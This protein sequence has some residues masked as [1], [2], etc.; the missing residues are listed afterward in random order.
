MYTNSMDNIVT[1]LAI[2]V[3]TKLW[4]TPLL[5]LLGAINKVQDQTPHNSTSSCKGLLISHPSLNTN[6][7]QIAY[8][9]ILLKV[10][11]VKLD[12][13]F[14]CL[15][16]LFGIVYCNYVFHHLVLS[17]FCITL[18]V[19]SCTVSYR[20]VPCCS[21]NQKQEWDVRTPR[22]IWARIRN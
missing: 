20:H 5:V 7:D 19:I 1:L 21:W 16:L 18:P 15:Q 6:D 12:I 4:N 11:R 14:S 9:T 3:T 2:F 22:T 17:F 8:P 10:C 13:T